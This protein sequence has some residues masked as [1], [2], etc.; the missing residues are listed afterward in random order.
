MVKSIS[1]LSK[2]TLACPMSVDEDDVSIILADSKVS[3][4]THGSAFR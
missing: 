4:V 3:A 1:K 2:H